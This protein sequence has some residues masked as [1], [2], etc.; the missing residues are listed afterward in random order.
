[1]ERSSWAASSV[2]RFQDLKPQGVVAAEEDV[3][4]L[5]AVEV[6]VL[7]AAEEEVAAM[8]E[9][10]TVGAEEEVCDE[11]S[12]KLFLLLSKRLPHPFSM[13]KCQVKKWCIVPNI[14]LQ[15][16]RISF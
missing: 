4:A 7:E 9:T 6:V 13:I 8:E 2:W 3:E 11:S 12:F 15:H 5:V 16:S 10:H 1:M 14:Q